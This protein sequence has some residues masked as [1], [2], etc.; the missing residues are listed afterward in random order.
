MDRF[1]FFMLAFPIFLL[2]SDLVNL[3]SRPPPP[4]PPPP[5]SSSNLADVHRHR[6]HHHH[7]PSP[8]NPQVPDFSATQ[9][10]STFGNGYDS[11][12]EFKF[13]VSCSYRGTA[14]SLKQMLEESFPGINVVLSNYPPSLPKR[15]LSKVFP[16]VQAGFIGIIVAGEHILPRLGILNPP[17]WYFSLRA[18]KFRTIASSWLLGNFL[19]STLQSSG[20]FEVFCNG[21]LVFSKLEQKRFP[22]ALELKDLIGNRLP[23]SAFGKNL[24]WS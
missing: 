11:T 4:P 8:V 15:V 14:N 12:I 18:N 13:C 19:Q 21:E 1:Q 16:V 5:H 24:N 6:H 17:S 10:S 22:D 3:Y 23:S 2:C 9:G 20:A 7:H